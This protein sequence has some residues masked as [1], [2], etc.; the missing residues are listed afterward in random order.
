MALNAAELQILRDEFKDT[1][2]MIEGPEKLQ[3]LFNSDNSDYRKALNFENA[4]AVA[5]EETMRENLK[6]HQEYKQKFEA[7]EMGLNLLKSSVKSNTLGNLK[8]TP[9]KQTFIEKLVQRLHLLHEQQRELLTQL[10]Q[11]GKERTEIKA[12]LQQL[13][14]HAGKAI[15]K[16][17]LIKTITSDKVP[18]AQALTSLRKLN[19]LE[20]PE[21]EKQKINSD[22][23]GVS[24]ERNLT[25]SSMLKKNQ[26]K[27]HKEVEEIQTTQKILMKRMDEADKKYET[28]AQKE[29]HLRTKTNAVIIELQAHAPQLVK[30]MIMPQT[31]QQGPKLSFAKNK[32]NESKEDEEY[33]STA[34][35][36]YSTS[37]K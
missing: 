24:T 9:E 15:E 7:L 32:K 4:K 26:L 6:L 8:N 21:N 33:Q 22:T 13:Q 27:I 14:L 3:E 1:F 30:D 18:L 31:W 28:L 17:A 5:L 29:Q 20:A 10:R 2:G 12:E 35:L 37:F 16:M 34:K 23:S 11:L 19:D 36:G 25:P